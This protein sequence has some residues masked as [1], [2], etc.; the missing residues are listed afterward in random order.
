[1]LKP[2]ICAQCGRRTCICD[3]TPGPILR[4]RCE[5]YVNSY[6]ADKSGKHVV[7]HFMECIAT[8]RAA[9]ARACMEIADQHSKDEAVLLLQ[10]RAKEWMM[11]A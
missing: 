8:E 2:A 11:K 3:I 5:A 10:A 6:I 9:E 1:M 7:D 4:Q